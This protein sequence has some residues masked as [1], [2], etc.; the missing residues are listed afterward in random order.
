MFGVRGW[1][2]AG[3]VAGMKAIPTF[4]SGRHRTMRG[5]ELEFSDADIAAIVAGYDPSLYEAP[6]VV[7]HP[8][9]DAPAYGWVKSLS[10]EAGQIVAKPTQVDP[11]FSAMVE[12][13]RFKSRSAKFFHPDDPANPT[14]GHYYLK[15]IGFLGAQAPAV[16]GLRQVQFA[17]DDE[18]SVV[19]EFSQNTG[20]A[21]D[22]VA[23][24]L[25]RVREW[26]I[27]EHG[28]EKAD[29][30]INDWELRSIEEVSREPLQ[31]TPSP[32]FAGSPGDQDMSDADKAR[33]A[34]LEAENAALKQQ[35]TDAVAASRAAAAS[36]RHNDHVAFAE[37]LVTAGKLIP[38]KKSR[39]VA[40]LD[41]CAGL[42][43]Q[44][45]FA[46]GDNT[47]K[48]SPGQMLRDFL[49]AQP[50]VVPTGERGAAEFA[51]GNN[52]LTA[53]EREACK[54]L[55]VSEEDFLKTRG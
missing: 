37:G 33:L 29:Q 53:A 25:R 49:N 17:G 41:F 42:D 47:V 48:T 28:T 9:L 6:L 12:A 1:R 19:V 8:Q 2:R 16:K 46:E 14:P 39:A 23:R 21:L 27:A 22:T 15:H 45:E 5:D 50:K 10:L 20:Y 43:T 38:A 32:A 54:N 35:A 52:Q 40:L 13:G 31:P 3:K 24:L 11:E 7:G 36:A 26:F 4:K 30:V 18:T 44:I 55:G 34:A 51:E